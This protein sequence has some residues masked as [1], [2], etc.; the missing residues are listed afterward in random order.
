MK[1]WK[2]TAGTAGAFGFVGWCIWQAVGDIDPQLYA[3]IVQAAPDLVLWV[4]VGLTVMG[5]GFLIVAGCAIRNEI[6]AEADTQKRW[7]DIRQTVE[8]ELTASITRSVKSSFRDREEELE[9]WQCNLQTVDKELQERN[10]IILLHEQAVEARRHEIETAG[11]EVLP[12]RRS[13][14]DGRATLDSLIEV[15]RDDQADA[16]KILNTAL[17]WV[18]AAMDDPQEFVSDT[19]AEKV[20]S[21]WMERLEKKLNGIEVRVAGTVH[22]AEQIHEA[23]TQKELSQKRRVPL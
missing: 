17:A 10:N 8:K 11:A 5:G 15:T 12:L 16:L 2:L 3:S 18:K 21:G 22:E 14:E 4:K 23:V 9:S 19:K 1:T 6:E 7:A 13:Y 20:N